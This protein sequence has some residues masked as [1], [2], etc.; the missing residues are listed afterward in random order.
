MIPKYLSNTVLPELVG[1]VLISGLC[2][3]WRPESAGEGECMCVCLLVC[4]HLCA[5]LCACMC[6]V[7]ECACMCVCV[8]L[9][10]IV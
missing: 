5:Y 2:T 6:V 9:S 3:E 4:V 1:E 7:S 10:D 8:S